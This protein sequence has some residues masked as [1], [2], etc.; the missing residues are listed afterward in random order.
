MVLENFNYITNNDSHFPFLYDDWDHISSFC[1]NSLG[2]SLV[3][4]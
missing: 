3:P 1:H 2:H 4:L